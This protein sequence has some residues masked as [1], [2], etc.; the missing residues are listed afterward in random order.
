MEYD[1]RCEKQSVQMIIVNIPFLVFITTNVSWSREQ[2]ISRT[3]VMFTAEM[4]FEISL[5]TKT[6][7]SCYLRNSV[8]AELLFLSLDGINQSSFNNFLIFWQDCLKLKLNGIYYVSL[9]QHWYQLTYDIQTLIHSR[10][11]LDHF[12]TYKALVDH[13]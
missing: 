8:L 13:T 6:F 4:I 11:K 12:G 10:S 2:L 5:N 7:E 1:L 9:E 3:S